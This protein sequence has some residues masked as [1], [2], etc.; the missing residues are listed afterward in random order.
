MQGWAKRIKE[1]LDAGRRNGL[2]AT[3][4]AKACGIAQPSVSQWFN[5]S[6]TKKATEMIRGDNLIA[7]A[8]YLNVRPEW[9]LSGKGPAEASQTAGLDRGTLEV[10]VIAVKEM[11]SRAGLELDAFLAAPMLMFAYDER[12]KNPGMDPKTFD[13]LIWTKLQGE[14]GRAGHE[15]RAAKGGVRSDEEDASVAPKARRSGRGR[16][17]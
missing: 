6:D 16:S 3:G 10:S 5:D 13:D 4:L 7:A 1:R 9:I 15:R 11:L 14:L 8:K 2:T 12:L 17:R